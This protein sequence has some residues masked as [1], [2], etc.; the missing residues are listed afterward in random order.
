M[1]FPEF[2]R[3]DMLIV[4]PVLDFGQ[5]LFDEKLTLEMNFDTLFLVF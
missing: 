3:I 4:R 2:D 1:R 5:L